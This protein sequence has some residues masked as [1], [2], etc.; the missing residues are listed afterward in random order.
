MEKVRQIETLVLPAKRSGGNDVDREFLSRDLRARRSILSGLY[1][2]EK[3]LSAPAG[4]DSKSSVLSLL[5]SALTEFNAASQ[6][7]VD[8]PVVELLL[9]HTYYNLLALG[10]AMDVSHRHFLH[11]Q[12]AYEL[13]SKSDFEATSWPAEI[14]G[15]YA[16][17][18]EKDIVRA[19][20]VF[21]DVA[22]KPGRETEMAALRAH[23]MLAGLYLG[24]WD[25]R[26]FAPGIVNPEMARGHVLAI[27]AQWPQLAE[28]EF[29]R[30]CLKQN[31]SASG[32]VIVPLT[33]SIAPA[34]A[35]AFSK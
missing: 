12:R 27:L 17:L 18:V 15:Y 1:S 3:S 35:N 4:K 7:D 9:A 25:S 30:Q 6:Y 31:Q 2:L 20:R 11:L 23:W 32:E 21:E 28:A 19:V 33:A 29:Y 14:E 24:D 10:E 5:R 8:N 34:K 26:V 16:L 22:A 13:R